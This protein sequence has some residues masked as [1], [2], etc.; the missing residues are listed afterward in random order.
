MSTLWKNEELPV[1]DFLEVPPWIDDEIT[2]GT[3][4][5]IIQGGCASG[6][7]MPA[8]TYWQAL[9]TMSEHG[10]DVLDCINDW[11]G[12]LPQLGPDESWHGF[13]CTVL[14]TG[15]EMWS[16]GIEDELTRAIED[17]LEEED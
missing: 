7:Y 9:E 8:V 10:D 4:A 5:A 13:A 12:I 6:A 3:I 2:A 15:V 14:S 16:Y 17:M 1:S 11:T